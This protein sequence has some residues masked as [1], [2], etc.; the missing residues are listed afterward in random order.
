[1]HEPP[2]TQ[3]GPQCVTMDSLPPP[4]PVE[5]GMSPS[6]DGWSTR[7]N[8]PSVSINKIFPLN[9]LPAI[10]TEG[11]RRRPI[12]VASNSQQSLITPLHGPKPTADDMSRF[13]LTENDAPW[14]PQK[15][16][17]V[18]E[19]R[20]SQRQKRRR[21]T[22]AHIHGD[23]P[24][25]PSSRS[26]AFTVPH[27]YGQFPALSS[28]YDVHRSGSRS[29][30]SVPTNYFRQDY[31]NLYIHP[32][33]SDSQSQPQDLPP[34]EVSD[35]VGTSEVSGGRTSVPEH[36]S[37]ECPRNGGE[38]GFKASCISKLKSVNTGRSF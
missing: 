20:Y 4:A 17:Y 14:N 38:C 16:H 37:L 7:C 19:T 24:Y 8:V 35:G 23:A 34:S 30:I 2:C 31:T 26:D 27:D 22:E 3:S 18:P 6:I 5:V 12:Q 13:R 10:A 15:T 33:E 1:M 29:A 36:I 25:P 28:E 9:R 21:V 11:H 32:S